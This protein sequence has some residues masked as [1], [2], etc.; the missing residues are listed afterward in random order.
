MYAR[1]KIVILQ[2][3]GNPALRLRLTEGLGPVERDAILKDA[4]LI[5]AALSA[6]RIVASLDDNARALF[7]IAELNVVTWV[8]PV[9]ATARIRAWLEEGAPPVDEWKLGYRP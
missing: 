2:A 5:E 8:N 1:K 7:H 9:S 6:D 3:P 4:H